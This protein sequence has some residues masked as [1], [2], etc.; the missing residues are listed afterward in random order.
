MHFSEYQ[1]NAVKTDQVVDDEEKGKLVPLLGLAGEVGTL[2]SEYKKYLRDGGAHQRFHEQVAED[3][4]DLLWYIATVATKFG[5]D[6]DQLASQ[7]LE[8]V[9]GRWTVKSAEKKGELFDNSRAHLLDEAFPVHEQLPRQLEITFEELH[10]N[11]SITVVIRRD[12]QPI[13]DPLTDNAPDD[14]G[15]RFHDVFHLS[16]AAILGWSPIIRK[17]LK[18]KRKSDETTDTVEDGARARIIE[19]LISQLVFQYAREHN[20]LDGI[21]TLDYHLLKTIHSLVHDREVR[22]RALFEWE[23]A[24]LSGYHVWRD[25]YENRGGTVRLDLLQRTIDYEQSKE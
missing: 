19:E 22:V 21:N 8:K 24:I 17:L 25:V 15:Y 5:L 16:Y 11:G 14:D 20:F 6:L 12:G 23:N 1:A 13:G 3:L 2:L 7:N 9:Q 18:V 4:G 10:E